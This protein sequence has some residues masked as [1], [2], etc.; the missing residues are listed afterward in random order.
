[1]VIAYLEL[2]SLSIA[3]WVAVRLAVVEKNV[4]HLT[5][6]VLDVIKKI[7]NPAVSFAIDPNALKELHDAGALNTPKTDNPI[8]YYQTDELDLLNDDDKNNNRKV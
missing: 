7:E 1:M 8:K 6:A 2:T 4:K 5:S 3:L